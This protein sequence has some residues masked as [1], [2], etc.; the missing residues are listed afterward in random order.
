MNPERQRCRPKARSRHLVVLLLWRWSCR[1][2]RHLPDA[3]G[4]VRSQ[5]LRVDKVFLFEVTARCRR[6]APVWRRETMTYTFISIIHA[7]GLT[8]FSSWSTVVPESSLGLNRPQHKWILHCFLTF[9]FIR[10]WNKKT[11]N[12][13]TWKETV[14]TFVCHLLSQL[15]KDTVFVAFIIT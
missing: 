2:V 3:R 12:P 14:K 6:A 8:L 15:D 11:K 4:A 13:G 7:Q 10:Q 1:R 9:S 5:W